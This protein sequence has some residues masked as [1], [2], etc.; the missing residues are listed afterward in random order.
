MQVLSEQVE[1][2]NKIRQQHEWEIST[3]ENPTLRERFQDV[4]DN[5]L[6]ELINKQQEVYNFVFFM[7]SF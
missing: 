1:S 2:L 5:L 6:T 3:L 7:S 4:L